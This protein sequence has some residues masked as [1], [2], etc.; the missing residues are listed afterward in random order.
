MKKLFLIGVL[1]LFSCGQVPE[2]CEDCEVYSITCK[3][4]F[5]A[6]VGKPVRLC[7]DEAGNYLIASETEPAEENKF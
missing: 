2:D 7:K 1:S 3:P 6:F 5:S 4:P